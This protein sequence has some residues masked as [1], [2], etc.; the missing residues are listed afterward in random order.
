MGVAMATV[1][2]LTPNFK[3]H[4]EILHMWTYKL[5]W[6]KKWLMNYVLCILKGIKGFKVKKLFLS[7]ICRGKSKPFG[8]WLSNGYQLCGDLLVIIW[9]AHH[10]NFWLNQWN[11]FEAGCVVCSVSCKGLCLL[12]RKLHTFFSFTWSYR[13]FSPHVMSKKWARRLTSL[14]N[15]A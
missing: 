10:D 4:N 7:L 2:I 14:V 3:T 8:G 13:D 15:G 1:Y 12:R 9:E 5:K 6:S 11:E